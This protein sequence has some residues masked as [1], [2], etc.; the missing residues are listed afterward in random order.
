MQTIHTLRELRD[1]L[2]QFPARPVFVPTMEIGR[3]HV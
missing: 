1:R 3:A 2:N